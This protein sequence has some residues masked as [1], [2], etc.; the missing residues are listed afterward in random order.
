MLSFFNNPSPHRYCDGLSRR[1]F[2]KAGTLAIGGLALSDL[3]KLKAQGAVA[4]GRSRPT[5]A[6]T[7]VYDFS[8]GAFAL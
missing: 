6:A 7:D 1:G 3:L 5:R 4:P 8:A 2:L